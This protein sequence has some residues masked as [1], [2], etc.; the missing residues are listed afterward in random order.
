MKKLA[1]SLVVGSL[2]AG[3]LAMGQ[4]KEDNLMQSL[5]MKEASIIAL[6]EDSRTFPIDSSIQVKKV[7]FEN[8]YGFTVA[9]D[10]YLPKDF[11]SHKKYKALVV[12]GPFGAV[13]E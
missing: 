1:I 8:R 3:G 4:A 2:L 12:S 13:K 9:G 5:T 10:M 11:D 6:T 7:H